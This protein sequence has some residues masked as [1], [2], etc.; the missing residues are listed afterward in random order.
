MSN[1]QNDAYEKNK[2]EYFDN[3]LFQITNALHDLAVWD[4]EHGDKLNAEL[5][6]LGEARLALEEKVKELET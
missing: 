4:V 1:S 6:R 2:K 5:T 3:L